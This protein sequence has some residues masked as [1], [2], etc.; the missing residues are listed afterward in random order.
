LDLAQSRV[1][2]VQKSITLLEFD[3]QAL[4]S[5]ASQA[6]VPDGDV[7]ASSAV[8]MGMQ[9][10]QQGLAQGLAAQSSFLALPIHPM[11]ARPENY[12]D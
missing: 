7:S 8:G 4:E 1:D 11:A 3:Y 5:R 9:P 10:R 6:S 2:E 12:E